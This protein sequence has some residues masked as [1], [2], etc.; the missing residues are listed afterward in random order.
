MQEYASQMMFFGISD[1]YFWT[2]T[3]KNNWCRVFWCDILALSAFA[4]YHGL[5]RG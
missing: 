3:Q 1:W 5:A 4:E 2:D